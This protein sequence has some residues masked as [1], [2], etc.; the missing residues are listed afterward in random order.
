MRPLTQQRTGGVNHS[1]GVTVDRLVASLLTSG[2]LLVAVSFLL[3]DP[4]LLLGLAGVVVMGV[5]VAC[6][7]WDPAK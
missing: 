1:E 2:F 3:V 6:F 4:W 7:R 5:G